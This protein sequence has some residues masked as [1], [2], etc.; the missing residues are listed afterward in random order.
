MAALLSGFARAPTAVA[1][2]PREIYRPPRCW[3]AAAY[4]LKQWTRLERGGHFAALEQ[5]ELLAADLQRFVD[6]AE[7]ERWLL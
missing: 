1:V 7:R 2:F 4:N 5:P 6:R 3:A